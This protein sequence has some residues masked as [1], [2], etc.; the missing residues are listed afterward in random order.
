MVNTF[1]RALRLATGQPVAL[2][3][4]GYWNANTNTPTL[5]SSVG[6]RGDFYT[7]TDPGTT[8]LDGHDEWFADDVAYFN[9]SV[10]LRWK[11]P[12]T[13]DNIDG[14][15]TTGRSIMAAASASA[16]I[17]VLGLSSIYATTSALALKESL[18]N[19]GVANGYAPLDN[20]GKIASAY[21]PSFVD[22][23]IEAADYF[24]LPGT[25]ETGKIYVTLDTNLSYRWS[26]S[27]YVQI[28]HGDVT[29][30]AGLTG[31]ITASGLKSALSIASTDITDA[32]STGRA[33]L[34]VAS[35]SA[36]KSSLSIAAADITDSSST[37]RAILAIASYSAL[38]SNLSLGTAANYDV[39]TSANNVV[40]LDGTGKL[41]AVDGSQLTGIS[42][43]GTTD[44]R[45]PGTTTVG[46]LPRFTDTTGTMGQTSA[47]YEDGSGNLGMGLT[48]PTARLAIANST[49]A[50]KFHLY[51]T[52]VDGSNYE[53]L[54]L[55]WST[56]ANVL[57][58]ATEAAG[59]GTVRN[60]S[61]MGGNVG[62]GTTSPGRKLDVSGPIRSISGTGGFIV[63][64]QDTDAEAWQWYSSAG[65]L[66]LLDSVAGSDRVTVDTSGRVGI[67]VSSL[68]Q[69]LTVKGNLSLLDSGSTARG[70]LGA[71]SWS[72]DWVA[73]QNAT[74]SESASN[75]AIG[76]SP[77]GSTVVNAASGQS[78]SL[79]VNNQ[80]AIHIT[81]GLNVGL[82][83][84]TAPTANLTVGNSTTATK[85][86]LYNTFTDS[87]N[88][89]RL[90]LDWTTTANTARVVNEAAGTG[91]LRDLIVG[92]ATTQLWSG[93]TLTRRWDV[94]TSGNLVPYVNNT[95][96]VGSSSNKARHVYVG[97][98]I[99]F[100]D[101]ST[102]TTAATASA[103]NPFGAL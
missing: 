76:Q 29:A 26:G 24:S 7:V 91:T 70:L 72:T 10:W 31:N 9:G 53:R 103:A 16:V 64:R 60:I 55:D 13:V 25:G 96:D 75:F 22:D 48:S 36:L 78:V 20:T 15:G 23:I 73:L 43:G 45:I 5:T 93:S 8:N 39:G 89:E 18:S 46:R 85:T 86:H 3:D 56:T 90:A 82:G 92:G 42:T 41:P 97:T 52:Y 32:S 21:L 80:T 87:L 50:T 54:A 77:T 37:G 83:G 30:V 19:K 62:I 101:G 79:R 44:T 57:R 63:T 27:A 59:T 100:S 74:L 4:K 58:I 34:A 33:I 49:A 17:A 71:P 84:I 66:Q 35:Y 95:Y 6:V 12:T 1:Q 69:A 38:K 99:V 2:V 65:K 47:L 102:Q 11:G 61:L 40:Q 14:A 68:S 88:Y 67:G 51:N 81:S 94:D 28:N 98:D